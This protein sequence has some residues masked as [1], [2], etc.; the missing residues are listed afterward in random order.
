MS[1]KEKLEE[2]T[3]R[4]YRRVARGLDPS[5]VELAIRQ[6]VDLSQELIQR[7]EAM[8][9]ELVQSR[10]QE[11]WMKRT[12]VHAERIASAIQEEAAKEALT[13]R[14]KAEIEAAEVVDQSRKKTEAQERV[15]INRRTLVEKRMALYEHESNLLLYRLHDLAKHHVDE[16]GQEVSSEVKSLLQRMGTDWEMLP[17]L[18]FP[19]SEGPSNTELPEAKPVAMETPPPR[20]V[21]ADPGTATPPART[22]IEPV[23][24]PPR[25]EPFVSRV[26]EPPVAPAL[27]EEPNVAFHEENPAAASRKESIVLRTLEGA[28]SVRT[29]PESRSS[30]QGSTPPTG[31]GMI[32]F[33]NPLEELVAIT[34]EEESAS[35]KTV[36]QAMTN[37]PVGTPAPAARTPP[38]LSANKPTATGQVE[39]VV[40]QNKTVE[41]SQKGKAEEASAEKKPPSANDIPS[42]TAAWGEE[43]Q[44]VEES[45][46]CGCRLV[47]EIRD[48]QGRLVVGSGALVTREL[49]HFLISKGLY[50]ELVA[51]VSDEKEPAR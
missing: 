25:R 32:N 10:E 22:V 48:T 26:P 1:L 44:R 27:R 49:I 16:L 14:A 9:K 51:S 21:S 50:G 15:L 13:V 12:L 6:V 35:Q 42:P 37:P 46:L 40:R 30:P 23:P 43:R 47:R 4:E 8:E 36:N 45:L 38:Q 5:E 33:A 29:M 18:P 39:A 28:P 34:A 24:P 20:I 7:N 11:G 17:Q 41:A 3:S 31:A 2:L 19:V